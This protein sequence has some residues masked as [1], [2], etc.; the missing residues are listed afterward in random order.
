V[1]VVFAPNDNEKAKLEQDA[2]QAIANGQ[3]TLADKYEILNI[4][5]IKLA[6]QILAYRIKLNTEAAHA[7]EMEKIQATTEQQV[8]SAQMAEEEK[9]KTIQLEMQGKAEL[10][11]LEY[12]LKKDL[13]IAKLD[14]MGYNK[15]TEMDKKKDIQTIATEGQMAIAREKQTPAT[16]PLF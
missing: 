13:E 1:K 7:R 4:Q 14:T 9:R 6:Q 15:D 3:I 10:L 5:N 16:T 8:K 11:K 2:N 12:A